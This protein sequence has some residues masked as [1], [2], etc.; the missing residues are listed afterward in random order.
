[1]VSVLHYSKK[2]IQNSLETLME[3]T[4]VKKSDVVFST[5]PFEEA[6]ELLIKRHR[7]N[8]KLLEESKKELLT[9][10]KKEKQ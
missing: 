10:W 5:I 1:L 6:L 8:E 7:E 3:I 4:L 2:R 9:N